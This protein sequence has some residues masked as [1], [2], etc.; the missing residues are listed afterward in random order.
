[1]HEDANDNKYSKR[2]EKDG[3]EERKKGVNV[4]IWMQEP[5]Y[6]VTLCHKEEKKVGQKKKKLSKKLSK[7]CHKVVKKLT[8]GSARYHWSFYVS[9]EAMLKEKKKRLLVS[10][11][12]QNVSHLFPFSMGLHHWQ[13]R[14]G[15]AQF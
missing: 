1:M 5:T 7:S 12:C 11:T 9:R 15:G 13:C 4:V 6:S 14:D 2:K 3:K 10:Q 8:K